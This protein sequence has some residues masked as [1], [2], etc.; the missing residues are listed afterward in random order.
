MMKIIY[1]RHAEDKLKRTD[2]KN[3]K[4]NKKLIE[5]ALSKSKHKDR[6][7]HGDFS[8][9]VNI[10]DRH[11]LRIIYDIIDN[12]IKVITFH[13]AREGRYDKT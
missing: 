6:T 9:L 4:I 8:H 12:N 5:N 3:F 7:K 13:I 11:D 1:T 2:I 10:S